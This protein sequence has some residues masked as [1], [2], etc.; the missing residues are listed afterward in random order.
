MKKIIFNFSF[1]LFFLSNNSFAAVSNNIK[2]N[3]Y[4]SQFTDT[5]QRN[6][7]INPTQKE[8][9]KESKDLKLYSICSAAAMFVIPYLGW[10]APIILKKRI[11]ALFLKILSA[12][13]IDV[14]TYKNYRLAKNINSA[15]FGYMFAVM[16]V[17]V[18]Y[19]VLI[20]ISVLSGI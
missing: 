10:I 8:L 19:L 4:T 20:A 1:L 3:E 2:L 18:F 13:N 6:K 17:F 14:Q 12:P 5:L 16:A 9:L 15:A 11:D 7:F